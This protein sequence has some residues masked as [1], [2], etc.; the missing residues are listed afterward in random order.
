M[1]SRRQRWRRLKPTKY[2]ITKNYDSSPDMIIPSIKGR[3]EFLKK[4]VKFREFDP[5]KDIKYYTI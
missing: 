5:N 4:Y 3:V 2:T 1:L